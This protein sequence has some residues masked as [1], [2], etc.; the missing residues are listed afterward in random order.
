MCKTC[1]LSRSLEVRYNRPKNKICYELKV[2]KIYVTSIDK[3]KIHF[4]VG[5]YENYIIQYDQN[6][7]ELPESSIKK[8][9]KRCCIYRKNKLAD[10]IID[11]FIDKLSIHIKG[12]YT[13]YA[14]KR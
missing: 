9:I 7:V 1:D 12:M 8:I 14:G 10:V 4:T 11:E 3:A 6:K 2:D 5:D 13:K